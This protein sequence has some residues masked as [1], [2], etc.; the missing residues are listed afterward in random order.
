MK[1]KGFPPFYGT[2]IDNLSIN[3]AT[4][5]NF[6]FWE[7]RTPLSCA[8]LSR[9]VWFVLVFV[10]GRSNYGCRW[11]RWKNVSPLS[12]IHLSILPRLFLVRTF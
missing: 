5:E 3:Q 2:S 10:S 4:C 11:F 1:K 7:K 9:G 12:G 8:M 6:V